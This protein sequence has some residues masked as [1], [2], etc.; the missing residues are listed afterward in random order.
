MH[1]AALIVFLPKRYFLIGAGLSIL[2]FHG[3]LFA[4][5]SDRGWNFDTLMYAD[6]WTIPGFLRFPVNRCGVTPI[7]WTGVRA[8]RCLDY[9]DR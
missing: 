1:I 4:I 3:L 8:S 7:Q 6:F 9:A 2:I 5:P